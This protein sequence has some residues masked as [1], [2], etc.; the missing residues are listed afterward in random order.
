MAQNS[1]CCGCAAS[2]CLAGAKARLIAAAFAE[3]RGNVY[4]LRMGNERVVALSGAEV[5]QTFTDKPWPVATGAEQTG[6]PPASPLRVVAAYAIAAGQIGVAVDQRHRI[7]RSRY[8][9]ASDSGGAPEV[10][11]TPAT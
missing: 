2:S 8:S 10:I 5:I 11:M 4:A 6:R 3:V 9:S 7:F 1:A